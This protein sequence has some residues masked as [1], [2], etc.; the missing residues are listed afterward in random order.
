M[1]VVANLPPFET[2]TFIQGD[3]RDPLGIWGFRHVATG[4]ASAGALTTRVRV[5]AAK[6]AAFVY[7]VEG[8]NLSIIS[9]FASHT[10]PK[11]SVRLLTNWPNVD[12]GPG[13]TAFA[14]HQTRAI[15]GD[16]LFAAPEASTET[17]LLA[18]ND[19]F[20]L[21]WDPRHI[22]ADMDIVEMAIVDNVLA[23]TYAFEVYGYY[24]DREVMEV[25]GGPRY[26]GSA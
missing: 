8:V 10:T 14:T 5:A 23:A 25:P 13:V 7:N 12:P 3:A 17:P 21:L 22:E 1:S 9:A 16:S 2:Q 11:G 4:D 15:I 20:I 19:R 26:P 24:W 18:P 6:R